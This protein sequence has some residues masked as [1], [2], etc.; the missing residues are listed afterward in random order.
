[1][2]YV[3][4][5]RSGLKISRVSLGSWLTYGN[6]VGQDTTDRIVR[7]AVD[8]GINLLDTADVYNRGEGEK[9]LAGAI[10][11]MR[12]ENLVI[13]SK[14]FFPMSDDVNDRGLSRKHIF[15]SVH[16]SLSR[17]RTDYLDLYQCHRHDPDTPL[18]E[19]VMAMDDLI[20][21]GKVLYWGVSE[22]PAEAIIEAVEMAREGGMHPPISNQPKYNL[23]DREIERDVIPASEK[24]GV[25]QI[26]FSPLAQGVLSGK[27]SPG[28]D[29]AKDTRA[30]NDKVNMFI[31]RYLDAARLG[32]AA[33]F[34]EMAARIGVPP[35]QAALAWCLRQPS[36]NSVIIGASRLEQLEENVV[37]GELTLSAEHIQELEELF[38]L[39]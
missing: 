39:S 26:V 19:T 30:G 35:S 6:S 37:A 9:A 13:A 7:R 15:E 17:L 24:Y 2:Q 33:R 4:L 23:F 36:V 34:A 32:Q 1:M 38:P 28:G 14:C 18:G 8:L 31:G 20:R 12:R 11:G 25:G 10:E 21:Q 29:P 16:Q 22:W 5:G 3:N 27:Y